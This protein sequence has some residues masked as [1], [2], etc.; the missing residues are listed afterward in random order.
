MQDATWS[1][2]KHKE[3]FLVSDNNRNTK[4]KYE[5]SLQLTIKTPEGRYQK[6]YGVFIVDFEHISHLVL[7]L[8][9]NM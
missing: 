4:K 5:V 6:R 2:Y 1:D 8:T 7:L 3:Q 9:L